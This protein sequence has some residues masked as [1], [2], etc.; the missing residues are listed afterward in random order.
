MSG[1]PS[2]LWPP[3]LVRRVLA[4]SSGRRA[5]L[6]RLGPGASFGSPQT[7]AVR[8]AGPGALRGPCGPLR[9]FNPRAGAFCSGG[10]GPGLAPASRRPRC[11][12]GGPAP[13][14]TFC[15]SFLVCRR[16][17]LCFR[18]PGPGVWGSGGPSGGAPA[19]GA[20]LV[21]PVCPLAS[22]PRRAASA[23]ASHTVRESNLPVICR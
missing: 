4:G 5:V 9:C 1:G 22:C 20:V 13:L 10:G 12:R 2:S 3:S 16:P 23:S 7:A 6:R 11:F 15:C 18:R 19:F 14:V 8:P 17:L 21:R